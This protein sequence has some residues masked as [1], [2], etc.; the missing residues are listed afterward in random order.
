MTYLRTKLPQVV[1]R[2]CLLLPKGRFGAER[3]VICLVL[4]HIKVSNLF[5]FSIARLSKLETFHKIVVEE[6]VSVEKETQ[7]LAN[8]E[9]D[10]VVCTTSR[11]PA[12]GGTPSQVMGVFFGALFR[13]SGTRSC[14]N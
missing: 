11:V 9:K 2:G 8:M 4:L 3:V 5:L 6:L 10:A 12:H 1:Q 7:V 14:S 13:T